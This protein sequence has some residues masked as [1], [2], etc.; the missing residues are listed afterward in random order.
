MRLTPANNNMYSWCDFTS[1]PLAGKC[2]HDCRYCYMKDLSMYSQVKQKYSGSLRISK[3]DLEEPTGKHKVRRRESLP[4]VPED[5]L[6]IFVCSGN[7]IGLASLEVQQRIL[8]DCNRKPDN[9]YLLQSKN[10]SGLKKVESYFPPNIIL[11][12]TVESNREDLLA[13]V[14]NAPSPQNRIQYLN[15]F[16]NGY[17]KMVSI[18]PKIACDVQEMVE[19]IRSANPNFV[20]IGADRGGKHNL[21][22]PNSS[23]VRELIHGLEK[24]TIV[25]TKENLKRLLE[26]YRR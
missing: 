22:E 16:D 1:N 15:E 23:E 7:D 2:P 14:S 17:F 26:N 5:K 25:F 19:L 3:K 12:T 18:E 10:P 24:F 11:G 8:E 13:E 21:S 20:S 9:F 6:V 4:F